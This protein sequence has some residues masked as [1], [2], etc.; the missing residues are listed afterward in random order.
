MILPLFKDL[1]AKGTFE[2][3][4]GRHKVSRYIPTIGKPDWDIKSMDRSEK[5]K[6]KENIVPCITTSEEEYKT[7]IAYMYMKFPDLFD[8]NSED[9]LSIQ[10]RYATHRNKSFATNEKLD[11]V[12]NE[13][14]KSRKE[15]GKYGMEIE[16]GY[17]EEKKNGHN[18]FDMYA[19]IYLDKSRDYEPVLFGGS[20]FKE[21]RLFPGVQDKYKVSEDTQLYGSGYVLHCDKDYRRMGLALDSWITESQLYRDS[22]IQFQREIQNEN[23]LAVT[24]K[25]FQNPEKCKIVAPGRLKNDGTRSGIRVLLDYSDQELI[26]RFDNMEPNMKDFYNPMKWNF[27]KRENLTMEQLNNFWNK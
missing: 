14:L 13:N 1:D 21:G 24:Q 11:K 22:M 3:I 17:E 4:E 20:Y 18:Q 23:S 7:V 16:S 10:W 26:N 6:I 27:L 8:F 19:L 25:M 12:I 9:N 2:D 5:S 15:L